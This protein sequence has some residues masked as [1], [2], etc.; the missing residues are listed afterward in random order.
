[1]PP[2][3]SFGRGSL[4]RLDHSH[5][6]RSSAGNHFENGAAKEIPGSIEAARISKLA[7]LH[8]EGI[9]AMFVFSHADKATGSLDE[10]KSCRSVLPFVVTT[11]AINGL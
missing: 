7:S 1:M 4:H 9:C 8:Y 5:Q 3:S 10:G 2:F 11:S 6:D